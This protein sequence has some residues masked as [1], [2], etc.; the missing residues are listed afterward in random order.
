MY[1]VFVSP[2]FVY[3]TQRTTRRTRALVDR[4][5]DRLGDRF[6]VIVHDADD[7]LPPVDVIDERRLT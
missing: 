1:N 5:D 4:R 6:L 2:P 7:V 3:F